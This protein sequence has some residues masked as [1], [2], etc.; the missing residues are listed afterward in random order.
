M[1]PQ[2]QQPHTP[3]SQ[4]SENPP[5]QYTPPP[6]GDSA[7]G[8]YPPSGEYP[9]GQY[10]PSGEY[11]PGQYPPSGQYPQAQYPPGQYTPTAA[12]ADYSRSP[13]ATGQETPIAPAVSAAQPVEAATIRDDDH[14]KDH[15]P[16]RDQKKKGNICM[17]TGGALVA[18]G[19][20]FAFF[21]CGLSL[22]LCLIG[23]CIMACGCCERVD[24]HQRCHECKKHHA[25]HH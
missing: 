7:Q 10:P 2:D 11:P 21:T 14:D 25:D 1:N 3:P 22:L 5:A 9:P 17:I 19:L 8:Q 23:F 18:T 4:G 24:A 15:C 6:V 12:P 13:Y 20:A 16:H